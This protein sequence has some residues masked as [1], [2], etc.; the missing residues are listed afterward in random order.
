MR[1]DV[2]HPI[3]GH[4]PSFIA[5][6]GSCVRPKPSHRLRFSPRSAGLCWLSPV[7][8]GSWPFPTLSLQSLHRCLDPYPVV[9]LQCFCPF[10][11]EGHRTHV[12]SETFATPNPFLHCNFSR[13]CFSRLQSFL[14][15]QAPMLA[16]PPRLLL[17]LKLNPQ[18]SRAVYATQ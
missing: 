5:H 6:T 11:P 17:P 8:A 4:Y 1:C 12:S 2:L 13:A 16:R 15:V 7:P 18:G 3:R 14:Y 9:F 10:L